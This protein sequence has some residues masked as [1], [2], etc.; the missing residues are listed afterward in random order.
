MK[1]LSRD[2]STKEKVLLL[3]L[4][5]VIVALVYY[6]FVHVPVTESL[7]KAAN[8][9]ANLEIEL[10]AV[11]TRISRLEVM[12]REIDEVYENGTLKSMPSY[13]NQKNVNR[14]LNDVLGDMGYSIT[15]SDISRRGDLVRRVVSLR[16]VAQDYNSVRDVLAQLT[17]SDYR[18][19]VG[20]TR[21]LSTDGSVA[22]SPVTV[23]TTLT[24]F[25]TMVGGTA[26]PGL[27]EEQK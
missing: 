11:K 21:C 7:E 24:F 23:T 3:F 16:F 20:D 22:D 2:F 14:L 8:E 6:Q 25:E 9:K 1:I 12:Q 17:G 18:C 15:F 26:D 4:I 5:V 13:N 19:L 10:E 27:P